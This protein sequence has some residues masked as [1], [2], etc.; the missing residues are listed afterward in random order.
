MM[1]WICSRCGDDGAKV[2]P[3]TLPDGRKRPLCVECFH[4]Y[5]PVDAYPAAQRHR[6]ASF[7]VGFTGTV[8]IHMTFDG[9][10]VSSNAV[11]N[12]F[13]IPTQPP[14][15]PLVAK[16]REYVEHPTHDGWRIAVELLN[17]MERD[18]TEAAARANHTPSDPAGGGETVN[19]VKPQPASPEY[20]R[21]GTKTC[22]C[23]PGDCSA[24]HAPAFRV[25]QWVRQKGNGLLAKLAGQTGMTGV[26]WIVEGGGVLYV[27]TFE[28]ATPRAGEW[29]ETTECPMHQLNPWRR[30][31]DGSESFAEHRVGCCLVP[32]NYGKGA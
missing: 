4:R 19:D 28:H 5:C 7:E 23:P 14:D 6:P 31:L 30:K 24:N 32:V 3:L 17:L 20:L 9:S 15:H 16:A 22:A 10:M 13:S 18:R 21:V 11:N 8:P 29:W 27:E 12:A 25:G 26:H 2:R 1:N